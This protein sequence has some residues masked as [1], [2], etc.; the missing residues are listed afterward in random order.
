VPPPKSELPSSYGETL[1]ELKARIK[2]ARLRTLL[3]ANAAMIRLYWD[4]GRLILKRKEHEGWGTKVIDRLSADL[5]EAFPD[6]SGL[7]TRN[8]VYMQTFAS[9]WPEL[10]VTQQVV[11]QIPW[12]Q[13]VV[14]LDKLADVETRLWYAQQVVEHGWSRNIL[15]LHIERRLHERRGNALNNF[16]LALPPPTS[17]LAAQIFKDPYLFDMLGTADPRR[18]AEVEQALVD[19]VQKFLLELGAGFAFVGRQVPLEVGKSDFKIDLLFYH[20]KLHC[21][22]VVELKSVPFE[23]GFIGQLNLYLSAADDLLKQP[24]DNPTIGL[25]LCRGKDKVVVEYALRRL[26]RPVG[27]ADWETKLVDKL[28]KEL[29]GSLP[30][31]EQIEAEL[32]PDKKRKKS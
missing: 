15:A 27:V 11:A 14:I 10:E 13:N 29:E 17:D 31:V 6:M 28:P 9:A 26:N 4:I 12:G 20:F 21:F 3:A 19:H 22:V 2:Q 18:E 25:L 1:R 23:P 30:T 5:R 8:L 7:S 16:A 32:M 24:E